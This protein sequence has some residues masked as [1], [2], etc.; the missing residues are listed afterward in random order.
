MPFQ[1]G[2]AHD[3]R[4]VLLLGIALVAAAIAERKASFAVTAAPA[5]DD[6]VSRRLR[7]IYAAIGDT[8]DEDLSH[9][10]ALVI[11]GNGMIGM[12]LDFAGGLSPEQVKNRV[13]ILIYNVANFPAYLRKWARVNG[14]PDDVIDETEQS[15]LPLQVM[16][17]LANI[18]RHADAD[19]RGG[20]SGKSP[21]LGE[22]QRA[23]RMTTGDTPGSL[24]GL[25]VTREGPRV[26]G[27]EGS[28]AEVT[29][30]GPILDGNG[31]VIG[32]LHAMAT[33]A[34]EACEEML[35]RLNPAG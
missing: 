22:V 24:I 1:T 32:D 14:K 17:D 9:F 16:K 33:E 10:P 27:S 11:A 12:Y 31:A 19:R 23:L 21:Q 13:Q 4:A 28:H 35:R 2:A 18:D 25:V 8:V 26:V 34:I 29:I 6:D 15:S 30:S 7:E 3:G 20:H 5:S